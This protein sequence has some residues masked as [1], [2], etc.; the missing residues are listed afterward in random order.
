M[1]GRAVCAPPAGDD[2]RL[3]IEALDTGE[4]VGSLS[5][6]VAGR[7]HD[8]VLLGMTAPEFA[9]AHPLESL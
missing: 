9:R 2:F 8:L 3:A 1:G 4:P 6:H 5:T 7:H